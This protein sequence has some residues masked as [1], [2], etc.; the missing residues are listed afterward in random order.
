MPLSSAGL[1]SQIVKMS[2]AG[3]LSGAT[4]EFISVQLLINMSDDNVTWT[5]WQKWHPGQYKA[6]F[7]KMRLIATCTDPTENTAIQIRSFTW[8]VDMPDIIDIGTN[9]ALPATGLAISFVKKYK[10]VPNVQITILNASQHDDVVFLTLPFV[11]SS[12]AGGFSVRVLNAGVGVART[13]N[14]LAKGY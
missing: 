10:T 4:T 12:G 6:R 3:V 11:N 13:I 1:V 14:W 8:T 9:V 7:F 2:E 5:D